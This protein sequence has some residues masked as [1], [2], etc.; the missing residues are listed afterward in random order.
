LVTGIFTGIKH[1]QTAI[2]SQTEATNMVDKENVPAT[3][4]SARAS[5][6]VNSSYYYLISLLSH[7]LASLPPQK[8]ADNSA[9][10][11]NITYFGEKEEELFSIDKSDEKRKE[12]LD[13]VKLD[14]LNPDSWWELLGNAPAN[15]EAGQDGWKI[16][17]FKRADSILRKAKDNFTSSDAYFNI[18]ITLA[19]IQAKTEPGAARLLLRHMQRS[20]IGLKHT[21]FYT[22]YAQLERDQGT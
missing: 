6:Q 8:P 4:T 9:T 14:P 18:C 16:R 12:R 17:A 1:K 19:E 21:Q 11:I 5:F 13:A 20:G 10:K 15:E 2:S 22:V 7:L 3:R